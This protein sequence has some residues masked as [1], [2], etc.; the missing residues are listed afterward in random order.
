MC[1][2]DRMPVLF[3]CLFAKAGCWMQLP[4]QHHFPSGSGF[5]LFDESGWACASL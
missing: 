4:I 5:R 2:R 3:G 1:F